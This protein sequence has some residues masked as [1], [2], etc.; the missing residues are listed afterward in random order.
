[1]KPKIKIILYFVFVGFLFL[2]NNLYVY[3]VIFFAILIPLF[4]IPFKSIKSG[5]IPISIFLLFTFISNVLFQQ[6]KILYSVGLFVITDEGL[7]I[8]VIRTIRVFFMIAGAK[9]LTT[10]TE[11]EAL[12]NGFENILRPLKRLGIPVDEFFSTMG[13]TIKLFPRLKY[14]ITEIYRG[15]VEEENIR[16]F[17]DRA[18]VVSKYLMPLMVNSIKSPEFYFV[19]N[20]IKSVLT[21]KKAS[22]QSKE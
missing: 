5:W 16:G 6:G 21:K 14:Q 7:N 11:V 17:L 18:K 9:M 8:A 2:V 22:E 3:I 20:S 19:D 13:L 4:R 1:M 12:M 10:T 15:K